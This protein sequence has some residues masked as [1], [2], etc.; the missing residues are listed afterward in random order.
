MA[1][2]KTT[3]PTLAVT[4]ARPRLFPRLNCAGQRPVTWVWGPPGAGKTTLVASYLTA[5]R[6]K[7]LWYQVDSGDEDVATFFYYLGQA[8]PRRRHA[9]P[10]LAPEYRHGLAIFARRFFRELYARLRAPFTVV[11]DNYQEVP[12][13]SPLQE[14][15]GEALDEILRLDAPLGIGPPAPDARAGAGGVYEHDVEARTERHES[16]LLARP[17]HLDVARARPLQPLKNRAELDA[18]AVVG[19]DLACI[20]HRGRER[21]RLAARACAKI[22]HLLARR[23]PG[24]QRGELAPLVLDLPP[25]LAVAGLGFEALCLAILDGAR[26]G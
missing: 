10:L 6:R 19:V 24:E 17:Q 16:G 14:V 18:I 1:L 9:L 13:D 26:L 3:Q 23:R 7:A 21:Q 15:V 4:V 12:D 22:E 5:R 25:A 2:A 20:L 11:F 8:A